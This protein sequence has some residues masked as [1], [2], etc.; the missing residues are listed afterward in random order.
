[1]AELQTA[2]NSPVRP[3][4]R[5]GHESPAGIVEN[6][7]EDDGG[8]DSQAEGNSPAQSS[9]RLCLVGIS[10]Y[11]VEEFSTVFWQVPHSK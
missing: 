7:G 10:V 1:M 4:E 6:S 11:H 5:C 8:T 2:L 9:H 3:R